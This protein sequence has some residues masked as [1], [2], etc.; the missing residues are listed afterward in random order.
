[1]HIAVTNP[2]FV[3]N[4]SIALELTEPDKVQIEHQGENGNW[5]VLREFL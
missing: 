1:M 4:L 5:N 2:H 3:V